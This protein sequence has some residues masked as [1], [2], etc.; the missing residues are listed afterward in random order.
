MLAMGLVGF[1][2]GLFFA[3]KRPNR[4]LLAVYGFLVTVVVYGVI[5]DISTV[6]MTY[7][8][9][10]FEPVSYTHLDVYKRQVY[11]GGLAGRR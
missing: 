10:S 5:S 3:K 4:F 11:D 8:K 6:V 1:I 2:S 7:D 9:P